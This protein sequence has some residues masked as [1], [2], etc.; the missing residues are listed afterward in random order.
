MATSLVGSWVG[1][2][3]EISGVAAESLADGTDS[4]TLEALDDGSAGSRVASVEVPD[5]VLVGGVEVG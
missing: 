3:E 4:T 2:A 5:S 1:V